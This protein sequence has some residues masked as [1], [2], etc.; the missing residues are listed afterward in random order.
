MTTLDEVLRELTTLVEAD[1]TLPSGR[2]VRIR[3]LTAAQRIE[4]SQAGNA[5]DKF[6]PVLFNAILV[7]SGTIAPVIPKTEIPK[8]MHGRASVLAEWANAIWALSEATPESLKSSD[9]A[10]DGGQQDPR[11]G[12]LDPGADGS[13]EA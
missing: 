12:A 10:P 4:A 8:L 1:H 9:P 2:V 11:A 6:D 5:G 3:E 13:P 7:Q